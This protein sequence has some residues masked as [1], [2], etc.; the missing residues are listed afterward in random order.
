MDKHTMG[1][2]GISKRNPK[3]V[4]A[5]WKDKEV[6]DRRMVPVTIAVCETEEDA[7]VIRATPDLLKALRTARAYLSKCP[8]HGEDITGDEW[9]RVMDLTGA[10]INKATGGRP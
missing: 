7:V 2:W 8:P 4:I 1:P 6:S 9:G 5:P 3:R 10:V